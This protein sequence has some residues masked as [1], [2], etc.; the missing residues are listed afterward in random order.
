MTSLMSRSDLT[1]PAIKSYA[2]IPKVLEPSSLIQVQTNSFDWLKSVGIRDVLDEINPIQDVTGSRFELH[3]G[4]HFFRSP[5]NDEDECRDKETTYE[6]PLYVTVSLLV[7]ET[8]E[9]KEQ[10][11]FFGDVPLMTPTGTFVI[12]GAERVVVS[13]LVR[14]PGAYFTRLLDPGTGRNVSF[15]KLI[16]YRGAWLEFETSP[17]D[18]ISVKIDRKRK[19]PRDHV[20]AGARVRRRRGSPRALQG[21]RHRRGPP[22]CEDDH[23]AGHRNPDRGPGLGRGLPQAPARRAPQR[24]ERSNTSGEPLLQRTPIR[25]RS[26]RPLQDEPAHG[27]R[28]P[29]GGAHAH[30]G[31]HHSD[32]PDDDPHQQRRSLAGRH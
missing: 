20:P 27:P 11:L 17:R 7:K 9:I 18:I 24:R 26:R 16:P 32:A 2:R 23:R 29:D 6:A 25:P 14:S 31:R 28:R 15:S 4:E 19:L 5:K 30:Q 13:Q 10:T 1:T 22:V 8:G 3:F 21:R 12:N